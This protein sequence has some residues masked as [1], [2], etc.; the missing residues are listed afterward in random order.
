MWPQGNMQRND[1]YSV[2]AEEFV[3]LEDFAVPPAETRKR[4]ST[5]TLQ[6]TAVAARA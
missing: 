1:E 5:A 4:A 3:A 2:R 6:V